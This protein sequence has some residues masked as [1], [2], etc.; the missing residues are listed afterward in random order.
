MPDSLKGLLMPKPNDLFNRLGTGASHAQPAKKNSIDLN[1]KEPTKEEKKEADSVAIHRPDKG[2][3]SHKSA[4][5]LGGG[6]GAAGRPK[7]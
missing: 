5:S 4:K 3:N 2:H 1:A 6:G 7:V